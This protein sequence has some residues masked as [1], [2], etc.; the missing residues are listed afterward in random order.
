[1]EI[2]DF[3]EIEKSFDQEEVELFMKVSGLTIIQCTGTPTSQEKQSF[4]RPI[5]HGMLLGSILSKII[6]L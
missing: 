4:K 1:M 6:G 2:G 5:V 3:F